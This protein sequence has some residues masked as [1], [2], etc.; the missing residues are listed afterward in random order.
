VDVTTDTGSKTKAT[1]PVATAETIVAAPKPRVTAKPAAPKLA[2][3]APVEPSVPVIAEPPVAEQ[4]A[5][6]A[7]E[8]ARVQAV[9]ATE[10]AAAEAPAI[11]K[12][13]IMNA[14]IQEAADKG[15]AYFADLNTRAK[16]AFEKGS[17]A[18]EDMNEF[19]KGNVEA[20]VESSKIAAKGLETLGQG[21]AE[22]SRRSF[23]GAT[24]VLKN[25]AAVKTPAEFLQ[26]HTDFVRGQFDSIVAETSKNTEAFIKLAGDVAQ[27]ISNRVA[28]AAEKIKVAA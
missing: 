1:K 4:P 17:K 16:T 9:T 21:Y 24:A 22:Y 19:A 11:L 20:V 2:K 25:L 15:Q 14:T 7:V 26:L 27:P 3:P 12:E 18:I 6:V 13:P 23:E 28:V 10:I 8:T 5:A